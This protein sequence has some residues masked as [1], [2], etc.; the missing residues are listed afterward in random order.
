MK[1]NVA[2]FIEFR[3]E[4]LRLLKKSEHGEVWLAARRQDG[5]LVII[6][7]VRRTG[8]PYDA[9]QKFPFTLPAKIFSFAEDE[10]ETV[11]VEEFIQ[12]ET[13]ATRLERKRFLSEDEARKILLQMCDGLGELHAK[14]IIHR[15]IKPS[16]LILQGERI[17]LIDF[18]AARIFKDDKNADT[19][20]FGTEGY[21]PPEQHGFGGRQTDGRSDIYSLGVTMKILL[22]DNLRGSLEEILNKC[23]ELDPSNRFQSVDELKAALLDESAD[24]KISLPDE[25][26]ARSEKFPASIIL[27]VLGIFLFTKTSRKKFWAL[28]IFVA[29]EIFLFVNAQHLNREENFSEPVVALVE[30]NFSELVVE[31]ADEKISSTDDKVQSTEKISAQ[32]SEFKSPTIVTPRQ[33]FQP[34]VEVQQPSSHPV[35]SSEKI[36]VPKLE[37]KPPTITAPQ[38][39]FQP[40]VEI[41]QPTPQPVTPQENF[42]GIVKTEFFLN[43]APFNFEHTGTPTKISR[44]KWRQTQA[45]LHIVN[46]SGRVW[47]NPTVKFILGQNWGEN[48]HKVTDTKILPALAVGESTDVVIPFSLMTVSDRPNTHAYI[49]IRLS[50]DGA[51]SDETYWS[52]WFDITD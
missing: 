4:K 43:D 2:E 52:T 40:P 1:P 26:P 38:E 15:D 20:L 49:Q 24:E 28:I 51:E 48:A 8:L 39:N 3:Y 5:E 45:R 29:T 13:L 21:A 25:K 41:Q 7:R 36:F 23:T 50:G 37:F 9:L 6:K 19:K 16:N 30:E 35:T 18:D 46:D 22:G 31:R 44:D 47:L 34:T 32:I 11:V 10:A 14:K 12:G 27:F 17:R 33:N 42:S